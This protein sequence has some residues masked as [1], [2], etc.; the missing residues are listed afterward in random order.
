MFFKCAAAI[1]FKITEINNSAVAYRTLNL[2]IKIN[3]QL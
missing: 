2:K 1:N 3:F